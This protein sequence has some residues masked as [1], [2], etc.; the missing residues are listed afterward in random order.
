M[1]TELATTQTSLAPSFASVE[2]FELANRIGKAFA[3]STLVPAQYRDNVANCIVALEMANRMQA[4]PLMVMQNL[5]IVHGNPGWSSK[6]LIACFNQSGRFSALRYEFDLDA[7]KVPY[8]C[9]AWAVEKSTQ[10]RLVGSTVT[11]EMAK[12]EGWSTKSGSKW[13]TM[14]ELMLQY[15]AAAFFVRV[16]APEISMG[17]QTDDELRDTFDHDT[18]EM[19][20]QAGKPNIKPV[21]RRAAP[22]PA[23]IVDVETGEIT[24][25]GDETPAA[26]EEPTAQ[27]EEAASAAVQAQPEAAAVQKQKPAAAAKPQTIGNSTLASAGEKKLLLN[28]AKSNE[29]NMAELIEQAGVG[30]MDPTTLEGLTADGFVAIKDLLPK[31]A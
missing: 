6:F 16:Y 31:A 26:A 22:I 27:A 12:A 13:K 30:P 25:E 21:S 18:G 9:R 3:A 4:S 19:V 2:G 24:Q 7:N 15:R 1:S 23:D 17:L 5:Y 29:L 14:P 28:R 20:E 11:L 10:E 8:G